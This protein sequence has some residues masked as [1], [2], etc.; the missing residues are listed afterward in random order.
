MNKGV[1]VV[2]LPENCLECS[3]R[4]SIGYCEL[5]HKDIFKFAVSLNKPKD[6]PVK[7]IPEKKTPDKFKPSPMIKEYYNP[8][9]KGW[10]DCLEEINKNS[11]C[12]NTRSF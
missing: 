2:D 9:D 1:I 4:D 5:S 11:P 8:Y 12:G 3:L 10:N 7:P 6:C